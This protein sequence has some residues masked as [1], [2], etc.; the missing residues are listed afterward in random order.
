MIT[1]QFKIDEDVLKEDLEEDITKY[2]N[3]TFVISMFIMPVRMQVNGIEL[4]E[5]RNDPW[6]EAPLMNIASNGLLS[7]KDLKIKDKVSYDIIEGPGDFEFTKISESK[8][9]VDFHNG[10]KRIIT[11]VEY[12]DLI[13]AFQRFT[14]NV[15]RFLEKEFHK[16]ISI[17]IGNP[18]LE[19]RGI[20]DV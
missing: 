12:N 20:S 11:I 17:L 2:D 18:G 1:I 7:V 8:V 13:N 14:D 3:V 15:R 9:N 6:G 4:F 19:V 16:Y 5:C 10:S